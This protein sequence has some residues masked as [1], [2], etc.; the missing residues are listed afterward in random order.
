VI[1]GK[2]GASSSDTLESDLAAQG[3][4]IS[5]LEPWRLQQLQEGTED[6]E[7]WEENVPVVELFMK[8]IRQWRTAGEQFLGIDYVALDVV[9]KLSNMALDAEVFNDFQV[10]EARAVELLNKRKPAKKG[11]KG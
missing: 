1:L 7:L 6:Y 3:L 11:R 10:M 9:A 5:T 8:T 2:K 4:D